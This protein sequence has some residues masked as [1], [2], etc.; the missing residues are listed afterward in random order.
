MEKTICELFAGVGGFRSGFDRLRSG[1]ETTW[2]SQWEPDKT[3][4]W[5][6][7]C[8]VYHYGDCADVKGEYHTGEDISSMNKNNIPNHNLLV[9]GFPCQDY[10]VAHSLSSSK[11]IEGK[12]G[13]L[14][15]QIRDILI[16]KRPPF[17]LL[18]NVDRLIK[19]PASQRGRDFGM[20][21]TSFAQLGYRVEWRVINAAD[22][23]A[24]QRRRR[25][26]IFAYDKDTYYAN[27]MDNKEPLDIISGVGFMVNAFPI[28][29]CG[30]SS[31]T[32]V[33]YTD[34]SR[35]NRKT[36][37]TKGTKKSNNDLLEMSDKFAFGFLSA[38]YMKDGMVTTADVTPIDME[39]QLMAD[40]VQHATDESLYISLEDMASWTYMKG[41]KKIPRKSKDGHEYIFS[42]G[43]IAFPDPLDRPA[44]TMLTSEGTKNRSTHVIADPRNGRLRILTPVETE[45]IQGFDDEWTK[46]SLMDG[47][48]VEMPDR[49]RRFC[50]GNALVVPM[51]TRMG[52]V[53][54]AIIANE[55]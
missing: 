14:W 7:D 24:V 16:T 38:G 30:D 19:S 47:K 20:I 17:V 49:M 44:R 27:V 40:I 26:F 53:L 51:V 28:S 34:V 41:A 5:A 3:K 36:L 23:G 8:Y 42:E 10:S 15:W 9:G 54:D 46:I 21:L 31:F 18:E 35:T 48:E 50:M 6:H 11:G 45:R 43:P 29:E 13:V 33:L 52:N 22:Y 2:F 1:W 39:A 25:T 37:L 32:E 4:Q 12:K 55:P